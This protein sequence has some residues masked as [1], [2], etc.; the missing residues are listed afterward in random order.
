M[1]L[2]NQLMY[3]AITRAQTRCLL[4][5]EPFAFDKSLEENKNI[6]NTW[7]KQGFPVKE[8]IDEPE[9]ESKPEFVDDLF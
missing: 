7:L 9:P 4:L 3:T 2:S 5:A 8:F 1:L 6:R